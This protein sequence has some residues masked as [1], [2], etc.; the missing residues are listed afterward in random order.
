MHTHLNTENITRLQLVVQELR[1]D[2]NLSQIY[3]SQ[4]LMPQATTTPIQV[5]RIDLLQ[6]KHL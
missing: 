1:H 6:I 3:P 4:I 2:L 5:E